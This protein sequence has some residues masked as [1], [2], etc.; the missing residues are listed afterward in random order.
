MQNKY[1][2]KILA[3]KATDS[4]VDTSVLERQIDNL[5]YRLY[6]LTYDEVKAIEPEFSLSRAEYEGS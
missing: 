1:I 6:S 5:V 3:T 2:D 4:K